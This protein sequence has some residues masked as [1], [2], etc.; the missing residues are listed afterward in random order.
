MPKLYDHTAHIS[1]CL[2]YIEPY[3]NLSIMHEIHGFLLVTYSL[4]KLY[5]FIS[6]SY[7]L[8]VVLVIIMEFHWFIRCTKYSTTRVLFAS[9][10]TAKQ[11]KTIYYSLT[12]GLITHP[13]IYTTHPMVAT[14]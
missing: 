9:T 3:L 13:Y 4:L 14:R 11:L 5:L 10:Y 1:H 6:H 12:Q 8:R 2:G 7:I